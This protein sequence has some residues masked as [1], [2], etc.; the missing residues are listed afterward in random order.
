[1]AVRASIAPSYDALPSAAQWG[2]RLLA[3]LGYSDFA[4]WSVAALLGKPD[5]RDL[6]SL[7]ADNCL[8][9]P[10][11]IDVT[12]QPRY[13]LHDLLRDYA[14][15]RLADEGPDDRT[16]A[17]KRALSGWLELA[18]LASRALPIDPYYPPPTRLPRRAVVPEQV[19]TSLV[20][21]PMAWFNAE[22]DNLITMT[23]RACSVGWTGLAL[24]LISYQCSF[25]FFQGRFDDNERVLH[26]VIDAANRNGDHRVLADARLRLAGL[27]AHRG[28]HAEAMAA[29][30]DTI[31]AIESTSDQQ[32]LVRGLYWQAYCAAKQGLLETAQD[33]A[34]RALDLSRQLGDRH[35]ELMALRILGS[36]IARSGSPGTGAVLCEESLTLARETGES[37]YE[38]LALHTLALVRSTEGRHDLTLGLCQQGIELSRRMRLATSEAYFLSLLGSAHSGL[39][40]H[41]RAI[42]ALTEALR[43]FEGQGE[44]RAQA[45]CLMALALPHR[46]LGQTSRAITHLQECIPIFRELLLPRYEEQALDLLHTLVPNG[47]RPTE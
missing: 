30:D 28:H 44:R 25:Q 47:V 18:D 31:A 17:L 13:R 4:E 24:Q 45:R 29:F 27:T 39:G 34:R 16:A 35:T 7:L 19:A 11:E 9:T 14:R 20:T 1:M 22:R 12:G 5:A 3:L 10:T 32:A 26:A 23:E 6:I 36:T 8:L 21:D 40:Q 38:Q 15:E 37:Y 41:E 2:F 46:S 42:V 43:I 33:V